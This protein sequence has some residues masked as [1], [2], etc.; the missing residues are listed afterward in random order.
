MPREINIQGMLN[1]LA[2]TLSSQLA[3]PTSH[4]IAP[5]RS[6]KQNRA[7]TEICL[8]KLFPLHDSPISVCII[9]IHPIARSETQGV[10]LDSVPFLI[11]YIQ[12]QKASVIDLCVPVPTLFVCLAKHSYLSHHHL[13]SG[14]QKSSNSSQWYGILYPL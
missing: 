12:F 9:T 2:S 3:Y 6:L 7:K 5:L 14:L 11:L 10:I 8:H 13:S 1:C 4:W